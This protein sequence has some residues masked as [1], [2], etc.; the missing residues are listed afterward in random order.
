M[1]NIGTLVYYEA[2]IQKAL[3]KCVEGREAQG[4]GLRL[5]EESAS[6]EFGNRKW[7]ADYARYKRKAVYHAKAMR[8]SSGSWKI[9]NSAFFISSSARKIQK[10]DLR[11]CKFTLQNTIPRWDMFVNRISWP[12]LNSSN[13]MICQEEGGLVAIRVKLWLFS[14][15][16]KWRGLGWGS[17]VGEL[18]SFDPGWSQ[19]PGR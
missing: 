2:G 8:K 6:Q 3:W 1:E 13:T 12:G 15:K 18:T 7:W 11:C 4:V 9:V 16:G 17:I 10:D 5:L 19:G 14:G